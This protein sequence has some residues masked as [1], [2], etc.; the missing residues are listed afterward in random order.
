[1]PAIIVQ[2]NYPYQSVKQVAEI[3]KK[4]Y[5]TNPL[6]DYMTQKVYVKSTF[7]GRKTLAVHEVD[8]PYVGEVIELINKLLLEYHNVPGLSYTV[9]VWT[10]ADDAR[11]LI[12]EQDK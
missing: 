8:K 9:D 6:P 2:I 11:D 12:L 7:E 10:D 4:E 5:D 1:M 3:F